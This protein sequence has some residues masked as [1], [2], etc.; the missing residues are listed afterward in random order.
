MTLKDLVHQARDAGLTKEEAG[1]LELV[2]I[3]R[4]EIKDG[5]VYFFKKVEPKPGKPAKND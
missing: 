3:S 5:C 4:A 1:D 2:S